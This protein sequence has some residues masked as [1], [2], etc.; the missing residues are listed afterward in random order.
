MN[1]KP[2]L[3]KYTPAYIAKAIDDYIDTVVE[4]GGDE[5]PLLETLCAMHN[6]AK[7][8]ILKIAYETQQAGDDTLADKLEVFRSVQVAAFVKYGI[9]NK[10]NAVITKTIL[11]QLGYSD[12]V[13]LNANV[14]NKAALTYGGGRRDVSIALIRND[15]STLLMLAGKEN[16]IDRKENFI[17]LE[18][19]RGGGKTEIAARLT[20][21]KALESNEEF[22]I[23]CGREIQRSI[24]ESVKAVLVRLIFQYKIGDLFKIT[25]NMI[26]CLQNN[27]KIIFLGLKSATSDNNDTLK[28]TDNARFVWVEEA[29]TISQITIDKL[30]PTIARNN[31]YQIVFTY[32]RHRTNTII[33][34]HFFT[35]QGENKLP[36]TLHI[37]IN[38]WENKFLN[39]E[40]V[41]IAE[42]DKITNPAKWEYIWA[43][44][45]QKE[46]EGALWDFNDI[47]NMRLNIKYDV[48]MY[49]RR[50]VGVDPAMSSK[51]FN[52]EYGIVVAGITHDDNVHILHDASGHYTAPEFAKVVS[53]YYHEYAC[54]ACVYES[55]Q[56]GEHI[57]NTIIS[58]D[59]ELLVIAVRAKQ[60]KYERALPLANATSQGKLYTLEEFVKLE[61]QML[62]MT[63]QGYQGAQGESP[64]RLDAM[65]WAVYE[66][67]QWKNLDTSDTY[68]KINYFS[69]PPEDYILKE[70]FAYMSVIEKD[71][72]LILGQ[73]ILEGKYWEGDEHL[74]LT[75]IY[76]IDTADLPFMLNNYLKQEETYELV[77]RDDEHIEFSKLKLDDKITVYNISDD[78]KG[79]TRLN[80]LALKALVPIQQNYIRI[81]P[82]LKSVISAHITQYN[83]DKNT[84]RP[85][86][87]AMCELICHK[88]GLID[89]TYK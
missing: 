40:M 38:Y 34:D 74:F 37:N 87:K 10:Y 86:L 65:G 82:I 45:P 66:L 88:K 61:N 5:P 14:Q 44:K 19:G 18:G 25:D 32:N 48:E 64:D 56:G 42:M 67:F 57:A 3:E 71:T 43:G 78:I 79:K 23:I 77:V 62:L 63:T 72:I 54:D 81:H 6:W 46:F 53:K 50:V 85:I 27:V 29:Q 51:N 59:P 2:V 52:N 20:L 49:K 75:K 84:E 73:E 28:S 55:N 16:V 8:K 22:T 83:P 12:T 4:A 15:V 69:E 17:I 35:E 58:N 11:N 80:D 26:T 89:G 39:P 13:N 36:D 24:K 30:I 21:I 70:K 47:K 31:S 9:L 68:F 76:T 1:L 33:H 41:K 60:G 7:S